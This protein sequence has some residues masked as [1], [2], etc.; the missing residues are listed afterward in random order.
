MIT[1][2]RPRA[3][4]TASFIALLTL[5]VAALSGCLP[6]GSG[7]GS[8]D[9]SS[10][11]GAD[12]A[13]TSTSGADGG[14]D[15]TVTAEDKDDDGV[16]DDV[17]PAPTDKKL[18]GDSDADGCDD[19][20]V[21]GK[22]DPKNDGY[23]PNGDGECELPLD[24]DCMNGANAAQDPSRLEACVNLTQINDDRL[25]FSE[26]SGGARPVRWNEDIWEVAIAHSKDMCDRNFFEHV[27]PDGE[28]PSDRGARAG[29]SFGLAE[30][31][32]VNFDPGGAQYAFMAEPTCTGH[33]GIILAPQATEV[34]VGYYRCNNP[35]GQWGRHHHV[36]QNYKFGGGDDST[37]CKDSKK[38]C[39]VPPN[40]PSV[41][42]CRG[43]AASNGWCGPVD[44]SMLPEWDCPID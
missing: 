37:F 23:D 30:N 15:A 26:E 33:R 35:N 11:S 39:E 42:V 22:S 27:N 28:D 24:Y 25:H 2:P 19:C 13:T 20:S 41:A 8:G 12:G 44:E 6:E 32:A 18:C 38:S 14:G 4:R 31:I 1:A 29:L 40:P 7:G 34:G 36:T 43:Q 17:D 3:L 5:C 21:K 16:P 9:A 10:T